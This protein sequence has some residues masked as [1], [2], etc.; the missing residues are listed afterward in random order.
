MTAMRQTASLEH[1]KELTVQQA[2]K[3]VINLAWPSVVEQLLIQL[4]N[5]VD[6][7]MVGGVGA[8]AIAAIGLTMQ[9]LFVAMA[10]FMALNVG[11]TAVV[12]RFIGAGDRDEANTTARQ[13]LVVIGVMSIVAAT[14]LYVFARPIVLFMGAK[15]DSVGYAVTYLRVMSLSFL[16]QTVSMNITAVLRGAGDTRTPMRYNIIANVVNV[17]GNAILI[18]GL[19][20]FPRWEVFGAAVATAIS[21]VV[22]MILALRAVTGGKSVLHISFR[23]KFAPRFDLIKRVVTVGIPAMIEQVVMRFAMMTFTRVVSGLGTTIYAAHQIGINIT[24][25]SFSPGMG[26]GMAATSL[27][28]RSLGAKRPDRAEMYGWQTRR[29]GMFVASAMGLLFFFGGGLLASLYSDE[30][31]VIA[32]AARVL[33]I[34]A[35]VQPLQ[36]TQFILAGALRGAGDTRWPLIAT[37]VGTVGVRVSLALLFV[38]VFGWGL[39]GAWLA[40]AIDQTTRSAFIY[41]RYRSG[42]WKTVKV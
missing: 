18:N 14:L 12:A 35:L 38:N 10:G 33:R 22:G 1:E 26:F 25:L 11:T 34:I 20:G 31:S 4:F 29:I 5:M 19:F 27:V 40:M 39:L 15:P 9:P 2:R 42:R 36:S 30:A 23:E 7:M 32:D 41:F 28:G 8:A 16:P 13:S 17:V 21:R 3:D 6:M 37:F 24:G